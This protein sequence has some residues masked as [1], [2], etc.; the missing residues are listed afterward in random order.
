MMMKGFVMGS[1]REGTF[2]NILSF[3]CGLLAFDMD[4]STCRTDAAK[5]H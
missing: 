1:F 2:K 3:P 5:Q 4:L